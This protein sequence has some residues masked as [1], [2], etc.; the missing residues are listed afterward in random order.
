MLVAPVT[1]AIFPSMVEMSTKDDVTALISVYHKGAQLVTV[2]TT[3]VAMLLSFFGGGMV[4]MWSGSAGLAENVAP[5]LSALALGSFL[6]GLMWMPYQCQ[7]AHGWTSLVFK[8]N[9][10]GAVM[11]IPAIFWVVPHYGALGA[12]WVWVAVNVGFVL[13]SIQFMHRRLIPGEKWTWYLADVLLPLG[14]ALAVVLSARLLQPDAY[15]SR[16]LWFIF[17]LITA[18]LALAASAALADRIRPR[19]IETMRSLRGHSAEN[20]R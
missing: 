15:Q 4:F 16:W 10:V 8:G 11:L 2:L 14:G 20:V 9:L 18:C 17:L 1:A 19:M 7:L 3:P 12:A 13:F 5:I 6:N